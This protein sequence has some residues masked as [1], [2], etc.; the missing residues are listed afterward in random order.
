MQKILFIL[1]SLL[2]YLLLPMLVVAQEKNSLIISGSIKQ[3]TADSVFI[4]GEAVA[5]EPTGKF[6]HQL[7]LDTTSYLNFSLGDIRLQL[8][9]EPGKNIELSFNT[10]KLTESLHFSGENAAIN[11]FLFDQ[12][13]VND[14]FNHYFNKH[15]NTYLSQLPESAFLQKLDSLENTFLSPLRALPD[16]HAAFKAA[17]EKEIQLLFLSFLAEYPLLHQKN[18][19]RS[20]RLSKEAQA[21]LSSIDLNDPELYAYSGAERL[22]HTF[23]YQ[24]TKKEMTRALYSNS[25]NKKLDA[26]FVVIKR[27]FRQKAIF[28]KVLTD[29]FLNHIDNLGI[30]NIEDRLAEFN[31][32]VDNPKFRNR[33]NERY[34]EAKVKRQDHIIRPYKTV[35]GYRLDA[36]IFLP[37]SMQAG[38]TYPA[39]ARFH[40]GSFYEGKPDWFFESSKALARKGWVVVAVE[41]RIAD[42]HGSVLPDAIADG[43]SLI[44]F[45]RQHAAEYQIDPHKIMATGNSAGATIALALATLDETL[46]EA[47]EDKAISS[48]PDAIMI[49]AGL[50]DL[51][52]TGHYWWHQY[53]D[54]EFIQ[55]I[56]PLHQV[57]KGLPPMFIAHGSQDTDVSIAPM[58]A[59]VDQAKA[60]GN[61]VFFLELKGAPHPIWRI[62]YFAKQVKEA[63]QEFLNTLNWTIYY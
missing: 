46:D 50:A 60:L 49:N 36:H 51:T 35:D 40:G 61:D 5:L 48:R 2:V 27:H 54:E 26:G 8:Y 58:R 9:A 57:K 56:S 43:K 37:D 62:P 4:E 6:R 53:F 19:G 59:Y 22:L 11:R 1:L 42:R 7:A 55:Q 21:R 33:I 15:I 30:K 44:R 41:Y 25:D 52:G 14:S 23:L 17:Y 18:T 39:R 31:A 10:S 32:L 24:E 3:P 28:E 13:T 45:L 29:F 47:E 12:K 38:K 34:L 20:L 16:K 63:R